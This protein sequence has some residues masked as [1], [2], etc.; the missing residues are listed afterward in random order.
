MAAVAVAAGEVAVLLVLLLQVVVLR[1]SSNSLRLSCMVRL[2]SSEEGS[3]FACNS[4]C[5]EH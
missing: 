5:E 3:L 4:S 1:L 2:P